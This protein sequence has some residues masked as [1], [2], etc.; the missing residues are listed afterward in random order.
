M[1][2]GNWRKEELWRAEFRHL[3][4]ERNEQCILANLSAVSILPDESYGPERI[5]TC[6]A[7]FP[8]VVEESGA[9]NNRWSMRL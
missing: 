3:S 2:R 4:F 6:S 1:S 8:F 9:V 7:L 5:A